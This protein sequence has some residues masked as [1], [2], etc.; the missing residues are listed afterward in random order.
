MKKNFVVEILD[1]EDIEFLMIMLME[2][3]MEI[4]NRYL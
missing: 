4:M 3:M 1:F 2:Y